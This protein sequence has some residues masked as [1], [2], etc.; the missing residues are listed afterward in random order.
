[1]QLAKP[2]KAKLPAVLIVA[3]CSIRYHRN[4]R[5]RRIGLERNRSRYIRREQAEPFAQARYG[6]IVQL[7]V[8]DAVNA[9]TGDYQPYLELTAPRGASAEQQQSRLLIR[10]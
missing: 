2:F 9:I 8:F 10:A 3:T 5:R 4:A 7:A 6:A 1:M